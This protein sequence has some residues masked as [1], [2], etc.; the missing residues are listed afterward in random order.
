[1]F[2]NS[3][4]LCDQL[5]SL[6]IQICLPIDQLKEVL[7]RCTDETLLQHTDMCYRH[8]DN[9]AVMFHLATLLADIYTSKVATY[10]L[11]ENTHN[12]LYNHQ[13]MDDISMVGQNV[14]VEIFSK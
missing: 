7:L 9:I 13:Y 11:K 2:L 3:K 4:H 5:I 8:N 14:S 12:F 10:Q 1:M 6:N